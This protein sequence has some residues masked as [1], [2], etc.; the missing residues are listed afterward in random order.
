MKNILIITLI[1][2]PISLYSQWVKKANFPD[3]RITATGF[4]IGNYGYVGGG[5]LDKNDV[6][7]FWRYDSE[8]D[9]WE[10]IDSIPAKGKVAWAVTFVINKKAYV[11]NINQ[12]WEYNPETGNWTRK[13][14]PP[15]HNS[16]Y[17]SSMTGF[18]IGNFGYVYASNDLYPGSPSNVFFQYDPE[19]D[20]W[21]EKAT[22]PANRMI[23]MVGFSL[24][25]KGYIGAGNV[26]FSEEDQQYWEYDPKLDEWLR[27]ADFPGEPRLGAVA[28]STT[29]FGY[30]GSGQITGANP[31]PDF[32]RYNP[33]TDNWEQIDSIGYN[34][35]GAFAFTINGKGYVG[36][37]GE[38][39]EGQF[40]EYSP[41]FQVDAGR[42]TSLCM[43]DDTLHLGSS[44]SASGGQPPYIYTW[45]VL[46]N[47]P[48]YF[49]NI[50][51][52]ILND[53]T[54]ANPFMEC[55]PIINDTVTFI[56][57]VTDS[58]ENTGSDSVDVIISSIQWQ[59]LML[60]TK[61]I[62]QGDSAKIEPRNI[63][64]GIPPF[65]YHWTPEA[66]LSNPHI[67]G[68]Y[69]SPDTTTEYTCLVTDAIGCSTIDQFKVIVLPTSASETAR[70]DFTSS[71]YP[72]PVTTGSKISFS[73]PGN[74][75]FNIRIMNIK[76]QLI[77]NE[78]LHSETFLIGGKIR[79]SGSYYYVVQNSSGRATSGNFIVQ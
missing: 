31:A 50:S 78:W 10:S 75:K 45:K 59:H 26:L 37:G 49:P 53:T 46:P 71:V 9:M 33:A 73:N 60:L 20:T 66:G 24:Q 70:P 56:L 74:E 11:C 38:T 8:T 69:A 23:S 54:T 36:G 68:P 55:G 12:L 15:A 62:N 6:R 27:I 3:S 14:D 29:N 61:T 64:N 57:T 42:D 5:I 65:S 28:F 77:L 63:V 40:W 48:A 72:N 39:Q 13:A 67:A 21:T 17:G 79:H 52:E 18:S 41:L 47:I 35:M 51:S 30:V 34:T 7:D 76:G 2:L 19:T 58:Y 44:P 1:I 32:W 4:S 25:G 16:V 22:C 43:C